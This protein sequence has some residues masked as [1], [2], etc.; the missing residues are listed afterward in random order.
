MLTLLIPILSSQLPNLQSVFEAKNIEKIFLL[1]VV[2]QEATRKFDFLTGEIMSGRKAMADLE[3]QIKEKGIP[4]EPVLQWGDTV[5]QISQFS[6]LKKISKIYL[7]KN[8]TKSFKEF[9]KQLEKN[10]KAKIELI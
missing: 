9:V 4:A 6:N 2:D 5:D 7:E 1:L 3:K 10:V 8:S